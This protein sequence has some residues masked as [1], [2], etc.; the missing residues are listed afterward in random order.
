MSQEIFK[1][2]ALIERSAINEAERTVELA[3]S[4]EQMVMQRGELEVLSHAAEDIDLSWITS[5]RAPLLLEHDQEEQIGVVESARLDNDGVCR[6]VV[7]FSK[8]TE[9]D[10]IFTDVVDG[11]RQNISVGYVRTARTSEIRDGIEVAVYKWRPLEISVVSVPADQSENV[12]IGRSADIN[13][14]HAEDSVKAGSFERAGQRQ[15]AEL[16]NSSQ[17][18]TGQRANP[19]TNNNKDKKMETQ[20]IDLDAVRSDSVTTERKRIADITAVAQRHGVDALEFIT[21][22]KSVDEFRAHVLDS[23]STKTAVSSVAASNGNIGLT[24]KEAKQFSL[25]RAIHAIH[26]GDWSEAGF[27]LECSR[28][29]AKQAGKLQTTGNIFV[30]GEYLER[31]AGANAVTAAGQPSLVRVNQRGFMD[32]LFDNTI[33]AR[34]GVQYMTGLEGILKLPKITSAATARFVGEGQDGTIDNITSGEVTLSSRTLIGSN[35]LTRSMIKNNAAIEAALV[36]NLQKSIAVA[37][38]KDVFA[39]ILADADINWGTL[40]TLDFKALRELVKTVEVQ[41]ALV[42]SAKYAFNPIIGNVLSTTE[43]DS[44]TVGMYL[45]ADDGS[46][47]GYGSASSN[48]VGNN[49]I[50]GDFSQ[51]AVG[52]W[53]TLELDIDK[54]Q[55]FLSGGILLRAMVDVDTAVLRPEAFSGYKNVI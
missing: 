12:G 34:L 46:V 2:A 27:E 20:N 37:I 25:G 21:S 48:T 39:K 28:A 9:A 10:E 19:N 26:T 43:K 5:G 22:G 35:E 30:P 3:F 38:D 54:S 52:N 33:A 42:D 49:L 6:A 45:R 11:I 17:N 32:V 47:A 53:G 41:N 15:E 8:N 23:I 18:E 4:S 40:T 29:A 44:N 50:F 16:A 36:A 14:E 13:K 24:D 55:K 31:A 1:R 51:V 7:R